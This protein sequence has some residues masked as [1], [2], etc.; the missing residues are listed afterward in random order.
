[1]SEL[2][3]L[4]GDPLVTR[5]WPAYNTIGDEEKAE[6][7]D[8]LESG[9]LSAFHASPGKTFG[10]GPKVMQLEKEWADHF[11]VKHAISMNSATSALYAAVTA[12]GIG[13]GDEVIVNPLTMTA[14]A[15][16]ALVNGAVPVFADVDP[17]TMNLDAKSVEANITP[18]T[19]AIYAVHLAGLPDDMDPLIALAKKHNLWLLE[20]NAQAPGAFYKG[21]FAG[22]IGD[23]G[24]FSLNCHKVIQSGEGG[25]A[26]TNDDQLALKLKLVRN[27]GEKLLHRFGLG[28]EHNLIGYNYRMTEMEAAVAYHQLRRLDKLNEWS[29][30]LADFLSA[31]IRREFDFLTPPLVPSGSTHV[32]YFYQ[33]E[34]DEEKA[35]LPL[36]LFTE[37]VRSEGIPV[38]NRWPMPLYR[39]TIYRDKSAIG[40][41]GYP[42]G[43]RWTESK[44][45]Y[46]EGICPVAEQWEHRS[47]FIETLV[48]WPNEEEEMELIV[49]AIRKV[50]DHRDELLDAQRK[51]AAELVG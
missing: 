22:T 44:V 50:M 30:R 43:E 36:D 4:G 49:Q 14:T 35:G 41:T 47:F 29:V 40:T 7:L 37:A 17:H 13:P 33:M 39:Q 48:R 19:K 31:R 8:V 12:C 28:S 15:S 21:R 32:Y 34:Y 27:H 2:A 1:M 42:F 45:S 9:V 11:G 16:A 20:D 25:I 26:V 6:V 51:G 18:R 3:L 5:E 38:A 10:G 24:V 23:I 46:Q